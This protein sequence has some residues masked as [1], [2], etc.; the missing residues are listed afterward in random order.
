MAAAEGEA[1]DEICSTESETEL[2]DRDCG[3]SCNHKILNEEYDDLLLNPTIIKDSIISK[4]LR[5]Y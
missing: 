2:C 1:S 5:F 4:N 3:T